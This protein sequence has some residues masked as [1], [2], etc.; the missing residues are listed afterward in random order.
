M[1]FNQRTRGS[2]QE[3][4]AISPILAVCLAVALGLLALGLDLGQVFV[5]K[6]ELQNIADAAALAGAKK[7]IQAKD[8]NNPQLAAVYCD[9]AIT[10]AQAV[11]SENRSAGAVMTVTSGDVV[12]GQWNL[13]GGS[14]TRTGCSTNPMEV[15][16]VQVTVRRDGTDNP[17]IS[18]FFGGL[19]G[20][21]QMNSTATAVAYLGVAGTSSL[22]IP[23]AVSP[24]YPAGQSPYARSQPAL[25]W[26]GP[27][28]A[29]AA[30]PQ[31]YTWKDLGG[32]SLDTTRSTFVMPAYAERTD[33][34]KLQKYIKGP[35]AGGLKYPQVT[36]GQKVYPISEY[37]WATNVYNNFTYLKTRYNAAAKVPGTNKWRVTAGVYSPTPVTAVAPVN[38]WLQL[39]GRLLPGPSQANACASYTVPAVYLQGLITLDVT[40]VTCDS[41]CKNYSYPDS[42]SCY[43][44]CYVD[45]EVPLTQNFVTTDRGSN[46]IPVQ[47][48]YKDMN[49]SASDVGAF[50]SVPRLVK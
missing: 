5:T 20:V 38:P 39:A 37:Q 32:S 8:P 27:K 16:A 35:S 33:L 43:K 36:V 47:K 3:R 48:D 26:L 24:N 17:T 12:L 15:T 45:L 30:N 40:G 29:Q 19:L 49:A 1:A 2:P 46:P 44:V 31:P 6:N 28:E 11:A 22:D 25:D 10:T 4:G 7:L 23:F 42:R 21:S 18:T 14:F 41:D 13:N 34:A 9:E 50:A